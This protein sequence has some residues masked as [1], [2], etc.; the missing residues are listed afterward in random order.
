MD[1]EVLVV[2]AGPTGLTLALCL[3]RLGVKLRIIDK[4]RQPPV[5]SRALAVQ[6]RTLELY[7]QLGFSTEVIAEGLPLQSVNLWARGRRVA[8]ID[9]GE[10]GAG[11]SPYSFGLIYPQDEHEH[12][13]IA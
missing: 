3:A 2:G 10:L 11:L 6:V 12:F 5:S 1:T 13:L 8:H 7:R 9:F 4:A